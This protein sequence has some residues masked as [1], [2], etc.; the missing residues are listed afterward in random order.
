MYDSNCYPNFC[1]NILL[2]T[3]KQYGEDETIR[4]IR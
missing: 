2:A 4:I 1:K 3:V